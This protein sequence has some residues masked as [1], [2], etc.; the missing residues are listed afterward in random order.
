MYGCFLYDYTIKIFCLFLTPTRQTAKI[1]L[2]T[3]TIDMMPTIMEMVNIP[4][5]AAFEPLQ[6]K[7]LLPMFQGQEKEERPA[8]CETGGLYGPWPSPEAHNVFCVRKEN[9]K[10][11][12]NHA[13]KK[14]EFYDLMAD[15][16]ENNNLI[17][18]KDSKKKK[19]IEEYKL[20]LQK[21]MERN[22]I[23][24]ENGKRKIE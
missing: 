19:E 7:S 11:I 22:G 1:T 10:I 3:R 15:L 8:F 17:L 6:G 20:L 13:T 14:W 2:Q 9:K 4:A 12:Y 21:E 18:V 24:V 23:E 5:D 16:Q